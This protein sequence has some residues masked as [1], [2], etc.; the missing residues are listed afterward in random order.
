MVPAARGVVVDAEALGE[1][2]DG[3]AALHLVDRRVGDVEGGEIHRDAAD[4]RAGDASDITQ[5]RRGAGGGGGAQQA[6]GIT[7]RHHGDAGGPGRRPARAVAH[8]LAGRH[9]AALH[10]GKVE[11]HHRP[12]RV[13]RPRRRVAAIERVARP[14]EVELGI[15]PEEQPGRVR[16]RGRR[17]RGNSAR[18]SRKAAIWR[19]VIGWSCSSAQA[20]WLIT[21]LNSGFPRGL[22]AR[23]LASSGLR[24]SRFMPVS[25]CRAAPSAQPVAATNASHSESS[26]RAADH[27]PQACGGEGV[28]AP[29]A[30][31]SAHRSRRPAGRRAAPGLPP[32]ARRR[33]WC[34]RRP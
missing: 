16:Q 2:R 10:D 3:L 4:H 32:P 27:R 13:C 33:R 9:D 24:P 28:A 6:V 14:G 19:A 34:S 1:Q 17:R 29:G 5:H 21:R 30:G 23:A 8:R 12:H 22:S 26:A 31:R 25:R 7:G 18:S 20:K 15:R 11:P